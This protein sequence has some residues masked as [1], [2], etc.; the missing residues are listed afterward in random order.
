MA[1]RGF[2]LSNFRSTMRLNDMAHVRAHTMA[3]TIK[4]NGRQP[5]QPRVSRAATTIAARANGKAKTV[6][7]NFTKA[8]HLR[9]SANIDPI[10]PPAI[11]ARV[12]AESQGD[13]AHAPRP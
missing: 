4:T 3:A 5:G 9:I 2:S 12:V 6:C 8:P 11:A 1:V 10:L 7:E 13:P